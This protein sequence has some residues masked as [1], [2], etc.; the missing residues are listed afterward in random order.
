M[1]AW[2]LT[3]RSI[4][5]QAGTLKAALRVEHVPCGCHGDRPVQP[6]RGC[7]HMQAQVAWVHEKTVYI[8]HTLSLLQQ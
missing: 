3:H 5:C 1:D 2:R 4:C 6:Y 7:L 8:A